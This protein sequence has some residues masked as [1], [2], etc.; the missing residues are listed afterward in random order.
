MNVN[1]QYLANEHRNGIEQLV[2]LPSSFTVDL[3]IT[4]KRKTPDLVENCGKHDLFI[5]ATCNPNGRK[6]KKILT[7]I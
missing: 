1:K 4:R 5:T 2:I 3:D 6:S 7:P